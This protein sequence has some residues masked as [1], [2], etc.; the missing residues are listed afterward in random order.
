MGTCANGVQQAIRD[1][2]FEEAANHIHRFLTLDSI[3]FKMSDSQDVKGQQYLNFFIF[4]I[5]IPYFN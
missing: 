1:K 3:V 5:C 2:N 4:V